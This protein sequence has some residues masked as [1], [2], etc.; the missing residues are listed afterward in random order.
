VAGL[1]AIAWR[2]VEGRFLREVIGGVV[3]VGVFMAV[4]EILPMPGRDGGRILGEFLSPS[5]RLKMQELAQ[6]EVLFLV[7]VFLIL[8][9][10]VFGIANPICNLLTDR[11]CGLTLFQPRFTFGI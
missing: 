2:V 6:Y 9:V 10:I 4:W 3:V 1:A 11:S 7:G 5:A 8:Q